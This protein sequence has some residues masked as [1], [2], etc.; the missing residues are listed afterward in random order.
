MDE[1][2]DLLKEV[3]IIRSVELVTVAYKLGLLDSYLLT[4]S[5]D[6]KRRLLEAVLWNTKFNGAAVTEHEVQEIINTIMP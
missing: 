4:D 3:K 2:S 6:S 5:K 1:F